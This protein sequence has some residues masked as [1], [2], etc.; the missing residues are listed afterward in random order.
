MTPQD[1]EADLLKPVEAAQIL[2]I[3][4][5]RLAY[6]ARTKQIAV[7]VTTPGGHRRYSPEEV[8]RVRAERAAQGPPAALPPSIDEMVRL[9]KQGWSIRQVAEKFTLSYGTTRQAI[10]RHTTL[11]P[12]GAHSQDRRV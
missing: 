6:L 3:S 12:K 7:A 10:Q 8:E 2:N 4:L 1:P 9:Y 11:R 5:G